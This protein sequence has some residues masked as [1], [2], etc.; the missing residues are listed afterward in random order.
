MAAAAGAA[1]TADVK[2]TSVS[3]ERLTYYPVTQHTRSTVAPLI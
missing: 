3:T 2:K 1:A